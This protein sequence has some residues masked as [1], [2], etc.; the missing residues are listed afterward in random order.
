[1]TPDGLRRLRNALNR[2]HV[3]RAAFTEEFA[4]QMLNGQSGQGQMIN[5]LYTVP[6]GVEGIVIGRN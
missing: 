2:G 1:M 3:V 4:L 6:Y 5:L